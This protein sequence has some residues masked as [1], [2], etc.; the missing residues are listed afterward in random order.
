MKTNN[1]KEELHMSHTIK[2]PR[3][4][5]IARALVLGFG[6]AGA[7]SA[8]AL[9]WNLGDVKLNL[10]SR[11]SAGALWRT[12]GASKSSIGLSYGGTAYSNN[13]QSAELAYGSG[14]L[15]Y[16]TD[17]ITSAF[18]ASYQNFGIFARANYT[19][20]PSQVSQQYLSPADYGQPPGKVL[21]QADRAAQERAIRNHI[22]NDGTIL[23]LY[24]YGS[25]RLF[26]HDLSFKVGKQI[27]NWGESTLVFNGLNSIVPLDADK[28]RLPGAELSELVIPTQ[29]IFASF[30]ATESISIEGWYQW[31]WE[32]TLVGTPGSFFPIPDQDFT[33][34]GGIAANT[35]FGFVDKNTAGVT[36][37]RAPDR[38]P[39]NSPEFG[40]AIRTFISALDDTE[41]D[42]YA[43]RYHSRLPVY[44][45]ISASTPNNTAS[46]SYFAEY[47]EDIQMYGVS[48]NASLPFGI[49]FQGEYSIKPNQ[50]LQLS[51]VDVNLAALGAPSQEAPVA[52]SALGNQYIRGYRRKIVSQFDFGFTKLLAPSRMFG[53]DDVLVIG[54]LALDHVHNLE[55]PGT[56]RYEGTHTF[57]PGDPQTA[58]VVQAATGLSI[59][60]QPGGYPTA[61]SWGYKLV[62]RATYNNVLPGIT[63]TPTLRWDHDVGGLTPLPIGNFVHNSRSITVSSGWRY[64]NNLTGEIGYTTYFGGGADNLFRDR[65]FISTYIRYVF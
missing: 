27:V 3:L 50:P 11:V 29:Q 15:I 59:P 46:A 2:A 62:A 35:S 61:T 36:I 44:S 57:Q 63:L 16:Q 37:L 20:D 45:A 6:L 40:G 53:W 24:G 38:R 21:T 48:F 54:E 9:S 43:A 39:G 4:S 42:F 28:A 65:D 58:A 22:A 60:V 10:D 17:K 31:K 13:I 5:P 49:G 30:T 1:R 26:D 56:L 12:E 23:D 19:Y 51:A 33:A 18:T 25:V 14:D 64:L 41:L 32:P 7:S 52:G 8:M 55:S 34:M 47:P